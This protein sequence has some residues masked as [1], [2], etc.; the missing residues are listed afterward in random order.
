MGLIALFVEV[1]S[2]SWLEETNRRSALLREKLKGWS[3]LLAAAS[4]WASIRGFPKGSGQRSRAAATITI[5]GTLQQDAPTP[6]P[7]NETLSNR[8]WPLRP[9][10]GRTRSP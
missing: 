5:L 1:G 6:H 9:N 4:D 10:F 7:S 3:L 8:S 2:R